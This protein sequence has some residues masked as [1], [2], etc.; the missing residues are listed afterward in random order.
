M[1]NDTLLKHSKHKTLVLILAASAA[2]V[3]GA[4]FAL[5]RDPMSMIVAAGV[6]FLPTLAD[7]AASI[8]RAEI[9]RGG[10]SLVLVRAGGGTDEWTLE[11]RDGYPARFEE[12]KG[13]VSGL[14]TMRIDQ[15]M[16]ALPERHAELGLAWPDA[17]GRAARVRLL[18]GGEV[19]ADVVVGDERANP[20]AQFARM[21]DEPQTFRALGS[22]VVDTDT[23]RWVDAELLSLP[24]GE[25]DSVL[26]DGLEVKATVAADGAKSYAA[27]E[28]GA[29]VTAGGFE[30]TDLRKAAAVRSLPGWL[31]RLELA[32]VRKA[33][34]GAVDPAIS[35]TFD[36]VRGT[37]KVRAVR[38]GDGVWISFEATPKEGAPSAEEIN[39]RRKHAGD[40]FVPDWAEF[41][42][43]HAG[44]EYK[45]PAWKVTSLEEALKTPAT[46]GDPSQ[47][48]RIPSARD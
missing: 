28:A 48:V 45:L 33:T 47:P 11:S 14:A 26:V 9:E 44:W 30:W 34:E 8:D 22:I 46:R 7:K 10:K 27:N 6:P 35:P 24:E 5:R 1:Q 17:A 31:A 23:R 42:R 25:V 16:T 4:V 20:R 39:A 19:V 2:C 21:A 12:L 18:A 43:K 15:R 29:L 36:M 41:A 32:D 13:I 37:L 40:P 3:A 38:D